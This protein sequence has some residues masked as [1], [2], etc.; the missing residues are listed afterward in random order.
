VSNMPPTPT[1]PSFGMDAHW[2]AIFLAIGLSQFAQIGFA[3]AEDP[4][5]AQVDQAM[6]SGTIPVVGSV[7]F[8]RTSEV[9]TPVVGRIE[10]LPVRVGD[11]VKKGD[12]VAEIE[13]EQLVANLKVAQSG[14]INAQTQLAVAEAQL[15]LETTTRDREARL[16]QSPAFREAGLE[17]AN[18][19]VSV[20]SAAVNAAK[21]LIV[22]AES[23]AARQEV[24]LKL[25]MIKAP[26][27]GVVVRHLLTVGSLVSDYNPSILVMVDDS[28]PEI[29][30]EVPLEQLTSVSV[31][32]EMTYSLN[33]GRR[34]QAKVRAVLPSVTPGAK[35][36]IVR[37]DPE[38]LEAHPSEVQLVTVYV[39]KG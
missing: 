14:V 29:E 3:A 39:P 28:A 21:S 35:T 11:H 36:R 18:N 34:H 17:D 23:E 20:A 10:S 37:L 2:L 32:T 30:I 38:N 12:V 15:V 9:A 24:N 7:V 22:S 26:F 4:A 31:G 16:K 13:T 5:K 8:W 33:S 25:A 19:R 1:S 6:P 27:D